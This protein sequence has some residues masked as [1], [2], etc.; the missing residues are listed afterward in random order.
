MYSK[1]SVVLGVSL[2]LLSVP[3]LAAIGFSNCTSNF[4]SGFVPSQPSGAVQLC[5]DGAIAISYDVTMVDPA[6][7]A[8]YITSAEASDLLPGRNSFYLDPDLKQLGI[9]QAPVDSDAY[10][11]SWNR[12]HLAPS[13]ILSY[14]ESTKRATYTMAN[15]APQAGTFNQQPWQRAEQKI[16][17]WTA[18]SGNDV[19][20]ITGIAYKSRANAQRSFDDIA[21]PDFYWTVL[22]DRANAQSVGIYGANIPSGS[23][24]TFY[25][26]AT[27]EGLYGGALFP[28]TS[29]RTTTF[30]SSHW[31]KW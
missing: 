4:A 1:L 23:T 2:A 7:S 29:C 3:A 28:S 17:D 31:W 22:C 9:K 12:G 21:V 27:I 6:W 13:H 19:Y 11:T 14:S 26:V 15:V 10:N 20:I 30:N 16:V 24:S 8:Y 5:K 18:S 25:S